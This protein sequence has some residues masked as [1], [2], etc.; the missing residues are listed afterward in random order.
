MIPIYI[1]AQKVTFY[2]GRSTFFNHVL[3][4]TNFYIPCESCDSFIF[5]TDNGEIN[6]NN[7]RPIYRPNTLG[8]TTIKVY[9]KENN[10]L[11][12]FDS[13]EVDV[14]ELHEAEVYIGVKKGG[15][16]D[17]RELIEPGA[18]I[19]QVYTTEFHSENVS[20]KSFTIIG[21]KT[22]GIISSKNNIGN[23]FTEETKKIIAN[24]HSG[25]KIAFIN[26]EVTD[27]LD[28]KLVVKP[29]EFVIK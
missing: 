9:K 14:N 7:C 6:Q 26:I 2:E 17:K 11:S 8:K 15:Q 4:Y 16:I 13:I 10:S 23:K 3:S 25:D 27:F 1:N 21:T 20:I 5:K 29:I 18:L 19:A 24:L 28:R 22:D 12:L